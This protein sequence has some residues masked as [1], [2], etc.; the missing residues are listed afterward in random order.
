[1]PDGGRI[2]HSLMHDGIQ[3]AA[4]GNEAECRV[5]PDELGEARAHVVVIVVGSPQAADHLGRR[6]Q[7]RERQSG[8]VAKREDRHL[9]EQGVCPGGEGDVVG[10]MLVDVN[11]AA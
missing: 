7:E 4:P 2:L 6:Q 8:F 11:G 3:L 10:Y 5:F 1:M 9:F